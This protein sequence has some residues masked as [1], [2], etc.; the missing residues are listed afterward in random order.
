M[1]KKEDETISLK[2][3]F[4]NRFTEL[5]NYMDIKFNTMDKSTCLANENLNTRLESMNEFRGQI[6]DQTANFITRVEHDAMMTKYD[7]DIRV[8]REQNA[9]NKGKANMNTVYVGYVI[10]FIGIIL[11]IV[12]LITHV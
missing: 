12:G 8:L 2:E 11:S 1:R 3:Y 7:A 4:D 10:A 5:K 6:K 9:E